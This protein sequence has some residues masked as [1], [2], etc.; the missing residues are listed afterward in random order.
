MDAATLY[1][2]DIYAWAMDQ[3]EAL[4]RVGRSRPELSN[5]VDWAHVAEEIED[6]GKAELN[7]VE[8]LCRRALAHLVIY[9]SLPESQAARGWAGEIVTFLKDARKAFAPSMGQRIDMD[10]M[11]RDALAEADGKLAPHGEALRADLPDRSPF[12]LEDMLDPKITLR[13]LLD[14]LPAEQAE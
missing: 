9:A 7:K 6:V 1:D 8:S 11:W 12:S 14:R 5:A 13:G 4:R 3:A 10:E 2:E